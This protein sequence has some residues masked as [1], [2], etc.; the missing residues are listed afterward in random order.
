MTRDGERGA[1]RTKYELMTPTELREERARIE[2]GIKQATVFS[3]KQCREIERQIDKMVVIAD[4]NG[5]M[6]HTVDRTPLR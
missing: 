1:P 3:E 2:A 5:Y 4:K 6:Q